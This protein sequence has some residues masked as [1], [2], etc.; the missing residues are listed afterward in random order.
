MHLN[1]SVQSSARPDGLVIGV[2]PPKAGIIP[3]VSLAPVELRNGT[4][5]VVSLYLP[6]M[7]DFLDRLSQLNRMLGF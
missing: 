6:F 3:R 7:L 2:P 4:V 5:E 1:R